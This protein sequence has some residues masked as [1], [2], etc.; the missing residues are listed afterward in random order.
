M[1]KLLFLILLSISVIAAA[2][3][4]TD[5]KET[6]NQKHTTKLSKTKRHNISIEVFNGILFSSFNPSYEYTLNKHSGIGADFKFSN[7]NGV[8][9]PFLV[10]F[11]FSPYYRQYFF[12]KDDYGATGLYGEGFLKFYIY[13]NHNDYFFGNSTNTNI[14]S[15][16]ETAI[17]VSIG[18][19]WISDSGFFIDTNAGLGRNLGFP[20]DPNKRDVIVKVS[21]SFG[22]RF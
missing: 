12:S 5:S 18:R 8:N 3:N 15:F 14:E 7:K 16:F 22:W 4:T 17:G 2:Q 13:E 20:D 19:K 10:K 21:L 11:S 9:H 6:E 1:K